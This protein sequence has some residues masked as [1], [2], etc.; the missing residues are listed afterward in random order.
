CAISLVPQGGATTTCGGRSVAPG[1]IVY[2]AGSGSTLPTYG[3]TTAL[4][5]VLSAPYGV[6][7]AST[8]EVY[9]A[10]AGLQIVAVIDTGGTMRIIAGAVGVQGSSG[11]GGL[12]SSARLNAP[13]GVCLS[14]DER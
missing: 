3:G 2:L 6:C 8:G 10:D 12:A 14:A 4:T 1:A 7:A 11:D 13:C 5:T 9:I